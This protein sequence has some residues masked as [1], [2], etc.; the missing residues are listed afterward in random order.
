MRSA[1]LEFAKESYICADDND[2]GD[3][4]FGGNH[5][6]CSVEIQNASPGNIYMER[7]FIQ[8]NVK[9]SPSRDFNSKDQGVAPTSQSKVTQ[10]TKLFYRILQMHDD[11]NPSPDYASM[12][13][14][15]LTKMDGVK[16]MPKL[17][18]HH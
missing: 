10:S 4:D 12:L 9:F 14:E 17:E 16:I 1:D 6:Q 7:N 13:N 11:C 5:V 3:C 2:D 18:Y 15:Q 8:D